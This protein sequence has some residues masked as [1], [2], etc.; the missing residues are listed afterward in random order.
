MEAEMLPTCAQDDKGTTCFSQK[1][2]GGTEL[3]CYSTS[4]LRVSKGVLI[5]LLLNNRVVFLLF[6]FCSVLELYKPHRHVLS[7][8]MFLVITDVM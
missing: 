6:F 1:F 4:Q 7:D 3:I 2:S 5:F 8:R